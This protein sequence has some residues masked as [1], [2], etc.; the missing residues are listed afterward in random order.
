MAA[1]SELTAILNRRYI[2][3]ITEILLKYYKSLTEMKSTTQL[4][5]ARM[6]SRDLSSV[7]CMLS[8]RSSQGN[9]SKTMRKY[10]KRKLDHHDEDHNHHLTPLLNIISS[11]YV[12]HRVHPIL[13]SRYNESG[14]GKINIQELKTMMEKLKAPQTHLGLLV[15]LV[16]TKSKWKISQ[17]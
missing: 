16:G 2:I 1:D 13:C 3:N 12:I 6:L 14:N 10:S 15:S 17:V 8:S 4:I 5:V 9:R 11:H 7:P